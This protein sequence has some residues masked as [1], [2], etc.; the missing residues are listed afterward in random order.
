MARPI[1]I[2]R[3][4]WPD[5]NGAHHGEGPLGDAEEAAV[6]EQREEGAPAA[7][8]GHASL[9]SNLDTWHSETFTD[10]IMVFTRP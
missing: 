2:R 8:R 7:G 6:V 4:Q 1:R 10:I 3:I 9:S 5:Y